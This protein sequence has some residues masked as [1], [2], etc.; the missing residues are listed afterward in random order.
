MTITELEPVN[1]RDRILEEKLN[2]PERPLPKVILTPWELN[3]E[4][5]I[6]ETP[7]VPLGNPNFPAQLF[8]IELPDGTEVGNFALQ[9]PDASHRFIKT[10]KLHDPYL[11]QGYGTATYLE[12]LKSLPE[13]VQLRTE[14]RL[15]HDSFKIWQKLVSIGLAE[16]SEESGSAA[17]FETTLP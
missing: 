16:R 11:H 3:A 17:R 14:G 7:A 10:I 8:S 2:D 15:N 13:G 12:I 1:S 9:E 4:G 6:S 5:A